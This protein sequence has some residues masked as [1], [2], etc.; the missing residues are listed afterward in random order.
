MALKLNTTAFG[1]KVKIALS[2]EQGVVIGFCLYQ[3]H[4]QPQFFVEYVAADGRNSADWFFKDQ[5]V[6]V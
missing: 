5:L 4:K 1:T 6:E 3:R 2:G